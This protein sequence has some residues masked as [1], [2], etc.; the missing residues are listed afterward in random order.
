MNPVAIIILVTCTIAIAWFSWWVSLREKRY[1]GI[2]R[3][4]SFECILILVL[5]NYP[6]WFKDPFSLHQIISWILLILSI[7]VAVSGFYTFYSKGKPGDQMEVTT[8][9]ISTGLFRYIRHPLYLSLILGGFGVLAKDYGYIQWI[10]ALI[11]LIALIITAKVEE[12]E[13][14]KNFGNDYAVYM[15]KTKMFIPFII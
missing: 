11:N 7:I 2:F 13:M 3:F 4:F 10:L 15:K 8:S 1:H 6:I 9:L 12:K 5:F 14:M